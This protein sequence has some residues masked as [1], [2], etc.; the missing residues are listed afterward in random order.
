[1]VAIKDLS[2]HDSCDGA[3]KKD[4]AGTAC[5]RERDLRLKQAKLSKKK[6]W[7]YNSVEDGEATDDEMKQA[8]AEVIEMPSPLCN[9]R[10]PKKN[11]KS[12]LETDSPDISE[13][14]LTE[15]DFASK[16]KKDRKG[17]RKASEEE[18]PVEEKQTE[19]P[20]FAAVSAWGNQVE[21]DADAGE[22]CTAGSKRARSKMARAAKGKV[23]AETAEPEEALSEDAT[24]ADRRRGSAAKQPERSRSKPANRRK[25]EGDQRPKDR[26]SGE[27]ADDSGEI[28]DETVEQIARRKAERAKR[29]A[30]LNELH[31]LE[32]LKNEVEAATVA[33]KEVSASPEND[34]DLAGWE[35]L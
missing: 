8:I 27:Q 31:A 4:R 22:W 3:V 21:E 6:G 11:K 18:S 29:E 17:R 20:V 12:N 1:M 5:R 13:K 28:D 35:V 26:S 33:V 19:E 10:S 34:D 14:K 2:D 25:A 9:E 32:C 16:K 24:K 30:Q 7:V 23:K 15:D